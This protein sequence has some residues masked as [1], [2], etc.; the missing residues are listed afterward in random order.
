MDKYSDKGT[1]HVRTPDAYED[2][3]KDPDHNFKIDDK[4]KIERQAGLELE[5]RGELTGP[6]LRDSITGRGEFLDGNGQVWDVKGFNSNYPPR[7]GG[8]RLDKAIVD[9]EDELRKGENVI[10]DTTKL[11][12]DHIGQLKNAINTMEWKERILWW[13]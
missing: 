5:V 9:I 7:K 1:Y 2:L 10:L 12:Q 4:T 11:S 13:P 3:A 8:F 6:I